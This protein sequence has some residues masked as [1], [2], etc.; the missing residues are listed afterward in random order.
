MVI[1][2]FQDKSEIDRL[3]TGVVCA[4]RGQLL[5]TGEFQVEQ[6]NGLCFP[7]PVPPRPLDNSSSMQGGEG[8]SP[9]YILLL[10]GLDTG[11]KHD[12]IKAQ[13]LADYMLG[14]LASDSD[15]R[16]QKV[17][18]VTLVFERICMKSMFRT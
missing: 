14:H 13:L 10:S 2:G 6:P 16:L 4:V 12:P 8:A 7:K 15:H 9:R 3:V 17:S 5:Q 18:I 11:G 1:T